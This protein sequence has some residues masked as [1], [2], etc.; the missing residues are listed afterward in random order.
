MGKTDSGK[1]KK[2]SLLSIC[3]GNICRSPMSEGILK[4]LFEGAAHIAVSSAG[5]HALAG[6]QAAT[7]AV[8][9]A[10]EHGVDISGHR[11]RQ[12]DRDLIIGSS[13]ILCM[14]PGQ[15]EWVIE[16]APETF[17]RVFNLA[18]FSSSRKMEYIPDPY[19]C[20]LREF[21][22]CF[23]DISVCLRNFVASRREFSGL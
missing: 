14:E 13:I 9:A 8:I 19:G 12:L 6:N 22:S 4:R 7:F 16:K 2:I 18:D 11:A 23:F 15:V 1:L 21:R 5:T 10:S 3:T 20:S 17:D